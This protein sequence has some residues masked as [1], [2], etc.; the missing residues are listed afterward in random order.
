VDE[1]PGKTFNYPAVCTGLTNDPEPFRAGEGWKKDYFRIA[2]TA[3]I[4]LLSGK[5]RGGKNNP[6]SPPD[7][8]PGNAFSI[9]ANPPFERWI[10]MREKDGGYFF[11]AFA[12]SAFFQIGEAGNRW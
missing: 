7:Q 12:L 5:A 8:S 11:H 4:G 3:I 10:F 9:V 6:A 2:G 1:T